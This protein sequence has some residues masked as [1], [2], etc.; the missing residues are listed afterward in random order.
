MSDKQLSLKQKEQLGFYEYKGYEVPEVPEQ[1]QIPSVV[2]YDKQPLPTDIQ[3]IFDRLNT[4]GFSYP[5]DPLCTDIN[6]TK[7]KFRWSVIPEEKKIQRTPQQISH[8]YESW[9]INS[10]STK[11]RLSKIFSILWYLPSH[12][13]RKYFSSVDYK[14]YYSGLVSFLERTRDKLMKTKDKDKDKN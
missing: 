6:Y 13:Y 10:W 1:I 2:K 4:T 11:S 14:F 7:N 8:A 3:K 9:Y 5:R 12:L